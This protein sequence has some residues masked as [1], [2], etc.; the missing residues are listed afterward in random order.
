M[1]ESFF[2]ITKAFGD[3]FKLYGV[4][5]TLTNS[6]NTATWTAGA[7]VLSGRVCYVDAGTVTKSTLQVFK[8]STVDTYL[9]ATPR[10]FAGS[11][12]ANIRL[13]RKATIVAANIGIGDIR[14]NI[15]HLAELVDGAP[16]DYTF[17][18]GHFDANNSETWTVANAADVVI[19]G[20]Y[21]L[22]KAFL[23]FEV[24]TSTV[25]GSTVTVLS[26]TIPNTF[27]PDATMKA[28]GYCYINGV[29]ARFEIAAGGSVLEI[30]KA[31][32]STITGTVAISGQ[33][34]YFI[35]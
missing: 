28:H 30:S 22:K 23:N 21:D 12:P 27:L 26:F 7:V 33:I 32:G 29:P 6:N 24:L 31:D 4:D 17:S 18:A 13:E 1:L 9:D 34:W 11:A 16:V 3:N 15:K 25:S 2:A 20:A 35:A 5:V 19:N 8:F 10:E 14:Y